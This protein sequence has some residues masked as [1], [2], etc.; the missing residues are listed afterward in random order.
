MKYSCEL[1]DSSTNILYGGFEGDVLVCC[2]NH[3]EHHICSV[4]F[5]QWSRWN[6]TTVNFDDCGIDWETLTLSPEKMITNL[7]AIEASLR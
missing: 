1:C 3:L 5:R 4:C 2:Q 7:Q 6:G